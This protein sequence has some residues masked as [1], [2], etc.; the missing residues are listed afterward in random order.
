MRVPFLP[1]DEVAALVEPLD[2]AEIQRIRD[3][4]ARRRA[5]RDGGP[6]R[7]QRRRRRR[8][9]PGA[10]PAAQRRRRRFGVP[11]AV[12]LPARATRAVGR[13]A[14]PVAQP[15]GDLRRAPPARAAR[16]AGRLGLPQRRHPGEAVRRLDDVAGRA[17]D[18]G[19]QDVVADRAAITTRRRRTAA[20][21]DLAE[22]IRSPRPTRPSSSARPRRSPTR[23]P[24]PIRPAPEQWYSFK[25][26][27]PATEAE[28]ADLERR[29]L[30]MQAGRPDPGPAA[31]CPA[32]RPTRSRAD[33]VEAARMTHPRA[34]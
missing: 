9:S 27:W 1:H 16:P 19:R 12:R 5:H 4:R 14:H 3:G 30:A 24:S 28:G 23:S 22:P 18:A 10:G 11:G 31:I 6:R 29:A 8:R 7:Q 21:R 17:G 25:P 32:T 15:A 34:A 33:R 26:I 13:D 20:P 2:P